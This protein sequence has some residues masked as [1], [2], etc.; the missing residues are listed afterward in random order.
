MFNCPIPGLDG[1]PVDAMHLAAHLGLLAVAWIGG[2]GF[3]LRA[4]RA[5]RRSGGP[6]A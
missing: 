4:V 1:T 5:Y 2:G 6:T 3:L